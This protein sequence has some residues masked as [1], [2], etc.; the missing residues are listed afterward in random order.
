MVRRYRS[1]DCPIDRTTFKVFFLCPV[2]LDPI[3]K[4][5][6]HWIYLCM[7][8][9][10]RHKAQQF[11]FRHARHVNGRLDDVTLTSNLL[12]SRCRVTARLPR[13]PT[14]PHR[15]LLV[16]VTSGSQGLTLPQCSCLATGVNSYYSYKLS[17]LLL[18]NAA[19]TRESET[20]WVK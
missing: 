15:F 11:L 12:L 10:D 14:P 20:P 6:S 16:S 2:P 5:R 18:R 13:R 4:L 1:Q 17:Q 19:N 7:Y 9:W 3:D 8:H